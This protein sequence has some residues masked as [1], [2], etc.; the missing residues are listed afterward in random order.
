MGQYDYFDYLV[1]FNS[2]LTIKKVKILH[3][4]ED[5]GYE[6]SSRWWLSQFLGKKAGKEMRYKDDIDALSGATI[7]AKSLTDSLKILSQNMFYWKTMDII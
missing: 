6:I 3:Y 5:Y 1:V 4:R 7:S 2:D